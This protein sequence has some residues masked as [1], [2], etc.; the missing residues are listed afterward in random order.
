MEQW[1]TLEQTLGILIEKSDDVECVISMSTTAARQPFGVLHGGANGV[2]VEHAGSILANSRAPEG[3]IA[4][5]T[6]LSVTQLAA[7]AT[8]LARAHAQVIHQGRSSICLSINV[9]DAN[10]TITAVG[11]LTCV[12]V[13]A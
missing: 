12:F 3:R 11:R 10:G 8:P 9:T 4:M 7:N 1:T 13:A 6:E 5:G 2:L